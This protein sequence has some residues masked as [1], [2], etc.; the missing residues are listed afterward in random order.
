MCAGCASEGQCAVPTCVQ[1]LVQRL[2]VSDRN[3][4]I[5]HECQSVLVVKWPLGLY[6]EDSPCSKRDSRWYVCLSHRPSAVMKHY[7]QGSL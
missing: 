2:E 7:D 6:S 1:V 5:V 3:L 4:S